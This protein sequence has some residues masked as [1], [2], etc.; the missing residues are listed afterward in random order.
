MQT[1]AEILTPLLSSSLS[2]P[3]SILKFG[4]FRIICRCQSNVRTL[5]SPSLLDHQF[6]PT[7]RRSLLMEL[8]DSAEE[9]RASP[10][11]E[12]VC[13]RCSFCNKGFHTLQAGY[14]EW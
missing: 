10:S 6:R 2:S 14:G 3:S 8:P 5:S 4:S 1:L 13:H 9:A 12:D 11:E 7:L